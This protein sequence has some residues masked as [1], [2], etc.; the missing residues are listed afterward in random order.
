MNGDDF[1]SFSDN[2]NETVV[3]CNF[4]IEEVIRKRFNS[5]PLEVLDVGCGA[6]EKIHYLDKHI[7]YCRGIEISIWIPPCF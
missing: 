4:L 6:S 5:T 1:I 3:E 2:S 7:G